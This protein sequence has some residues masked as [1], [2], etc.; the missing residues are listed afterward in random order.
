MA[1]KDRHSQ[2]NPLAEGPGICSFFFLFFRTHTPK[3]KLIGSGTMSLKRR[4]KWLK[5]PSYVVQLVAPT[6]SPCFLMKSM[7]WWRPIADWLLTTEQL[8]K[9][10]IL[11][12]HPLQFD[13]DRPPAA[14]EYSSTCCSSCNQPRTYEPT[15]RINK[16]AVKHRIIALLI[17]PSR[18]FSPIQQSLNT[19]SAH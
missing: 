6:G 1:N 4:K 12:N 15:N 11:C 3:L 17:H 5:L 19:E 16:P 7:G 10:S 14:A 8:M 2:T 9:P 18:V 13:G